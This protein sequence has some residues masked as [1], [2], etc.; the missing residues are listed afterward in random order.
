[1]N[2]EEDCVSAGGVWSDLSECLNIILP[3]K[4]TLFTKFY[5]YEN[6]PKMFILSE[7]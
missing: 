6:H 3:S 4:V 2:T 5:F 1:M 7:N